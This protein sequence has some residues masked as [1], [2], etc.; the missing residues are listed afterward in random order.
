M[1]TLVVGDKNLSSW[2]LRPWLVLKRF[3]FAFREI[4]LRLDTP[5]FQTQIRQYSPALRVPVLIDED[6]HI[7]DSLAI[8]EYLNEK[9]QGKGWP[10]HAAARAHARSIAAEMHSGFAA[11]RT[12][13]TMRAVG[14]N[15]SISLT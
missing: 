13:W 7:W 8:A 15:S 1:L 14:R 11:L 6:L 9:T 4:N 2:S 12:E 10:A 5:E 3:G